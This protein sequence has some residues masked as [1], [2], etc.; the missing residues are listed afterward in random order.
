MDAVVNHEGKKA[1]FCDAQSPDCIEGWLLQGHWYELPNL[2]FIQNLHVTGNY[3]DAGSYIG[4]HA[5]FFSMFCP[6][7]RI[8]AFEPQADIYQKL[9]RNLELNGITNIKAFNLGLS[10]APGRGNAN[11]PESNKGG[12]W[13]RSGDTVDV[14][15]LDSLNLPDVRLMKVDVEGMELQVLQGATETLKGVQHLFV[16]MWQ[17]HTCEA[18]GAAYTFDSVVAFLKPLGI[19]YQTELKDDLHYFKRV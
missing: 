16:E 14:V 18:R 15:T 7:A 5:I 1:V 4:T 6:A 2:Q 17:K 9:N 12:A 8:F 19:E 13:L 3:V 11:G 10:D